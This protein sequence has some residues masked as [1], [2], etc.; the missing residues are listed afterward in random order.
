MQQ[1]LTMDPLDMSSH[2]ALHRAK[3][4]QSW[5][6]SAQ[7]IGCHPFLDLLDAYRQAR[8]K[9]WAVRRICMI[10]ELKITGIGVCCKAVFP[11]DSDDLGSVEYEKI[12]PEDRAL[13]DTKSDSLNSRHLAIVA[14]RL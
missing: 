14:D 13:R 5:R 9:R 6:R 8:N 7:T 2:T 12:W 4:I 3:S 11:G 1:R 10:V